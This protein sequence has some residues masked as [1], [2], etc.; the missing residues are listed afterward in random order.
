MNL[1]GLWRESVGASK[2]S[3]NA[4]VQGDELKCRN[5]MRTLPRRAGS[6]IPCFLALV[7]M[8]P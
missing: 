3:M 7:L 4:K 1:Q 8:R 2:E 5:A 6:L